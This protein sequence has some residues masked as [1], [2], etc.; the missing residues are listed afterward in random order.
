MQKINSIKYLGFITGWIQA[1]EEKTRIKFN[2]SWFFSV[3]LI[4]AVFYPVSRYNYLLFHFMAEIFSVIIACMVFVLAWH[5]RRYADNHYFIFLG[6]AYLFVAGLDIIHA[7]T[8]TGMNIFPG[9]DANLPTQLWVAARYLEAFAL[10]AAPLLL[11]RKISIKAV[12]A[13]Y[14]TIFTLI[15]ATIF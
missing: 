11:F 14:G 9:Y 10:L 6:I 4:L 15:T 3:I 1:A 5:S 7:L 8:F 13:G 12:F 2:L